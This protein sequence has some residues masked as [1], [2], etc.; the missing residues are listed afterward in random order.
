M[1]KETVKEVAKPKKQS[2]I[3]VIVES[4]LAL[5]TH[6]LEVLWNT[7]TNSNTPIIIEAIKAESEKLKAL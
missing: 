2:E 1:K 6:V 7:V 3:E 4:V 5:Q